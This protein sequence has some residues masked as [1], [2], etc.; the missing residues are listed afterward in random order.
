M[1]KPSSDPDKRSNF[2]NCIR[3]AVV[4]WSLAIVLF[5]LGSAALG[6]PIYRDMHIGTALEYA[7]GPINIFKPIVVG[8][9]LNNTPTPQELPI[10]QAVAG[11]FFKLFGTWLGW[12]NLV[13][14]LFFFSCLYPLFRLAQ[15]FAGPES[16]WWTLL[17]FLAQPVIFV[18]AGEG[19]TDG[20]SLSTA[21]WFMFFA[22]RLW[23]E[24]TLKWLVL[25]AIMGAWAAVSK[26]PFFT[27]AGFGCLFMTI[28]RYRNNRPAFLYLTVAA[29]VIGAAFFGWSRYMDYRYSQAELPFVDLRLSD[30]KEFWWFFGDLKYRFSPGAWIKGIW[31]VF[32]AH[33]GSFALMALLLLSFLRKSYSR[34]AGWWI[35]GGLVTAFIFFHVVFHHDHYNLMFAPPVAILCAQVAPV[36]ESALTSLV[37][38]KQTAGLAI[39]LAGLA[40]STAQGVITRN[41]VVFFSAYPTEMSNVIKKHTAPTDKLLIQGGG[42]GGQLLF[43]S[44]R[45]G[46]SIFDTTLLEDHKTY[47]RLRSRGFNK[48][49][50]V[51]EMPLLTA[52]RQTHNAA[53]TEKRDTYQTRMTPIAEKFPRVLQ[54]ADI[55]IMELP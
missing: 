8:F 48:L 5:H 44:D 18:F 30:A 51:S 15:Q 40:L 9:N 6:R 42:W 54:T 52:I 3:I 14:L 13:S 41:I 31:H 16:A 38:G 49:V 25:T 17:L 32:I 45:K 23:R 2:Q 46:L 12:A 37:P 53:T 33:F 34:L 47:E 36:L 55:L 1:N 26:L 11:L 7:K 39:V 35:A 50:M 19:G 21:V 22:T 29:S 27:A 20:L 43:L 24:Q 4:L 28:A 10:W